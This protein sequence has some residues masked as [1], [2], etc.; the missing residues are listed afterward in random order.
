MIQKRDLHASAQI[1]K[2]HTKTK[3]LRVRIVVCQQEEG[4]LL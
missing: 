2:R 3:R 1:V 4:G